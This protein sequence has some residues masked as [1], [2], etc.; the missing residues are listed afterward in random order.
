MASFLRFYS[1]ITQVV[2]LYDA[3]LEKL[4]LYGSWLKRM[5]PTREAPQGGDVT[6]DMLAL[7]AYKL[8]AIGEA[9]DARLDRDAT[10]ALKPIVEFGANPYTEE[11]ARTLSEIIDAF[12][13][14]H[15]TN[16]TVS[17]VLAPP[18]C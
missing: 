6:D 1:F 11:E 3:D 10:E 15:N 17:A 12:N 13:N 8:T 5:I 18:S 2:N 16:F 14:R 9:V 7:E 4:H